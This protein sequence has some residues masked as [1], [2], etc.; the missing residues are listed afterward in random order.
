MGRLPGWV[1]ARWDP[2]PT[3]GPHD[4]IS[5]VMDDRSEGLR[6]GDP[7]LAD[8]LA[9]LRGQVDEMTRLLLERSQQVEELQSEADCLLA[10]LASSAS[11]HEREMS[12]LTADHLR[13]TSMLSSRLSDAE[14]QLQ[15]V[16]TTLSWRVTKPLR[17]IRTLLP[18]PKHVP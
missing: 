16:K 5:G 11:A 12:E 2:P 17:L 1:P 7:P 9:A 8:E 10:K 6:S 14:T 4:Y 3:R 15:A 18:R 13:E